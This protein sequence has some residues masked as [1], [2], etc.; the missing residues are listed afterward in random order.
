MNETHL[1]AAGRAEANIGT[2]RLEIVE[3]ATRRD[4]TIRVLS[5]Q[6]YLQVVAF[7]CSKT[8]IASGVYDNTIGKLEPFQNFFGIIGQR[9]EFG[10]RIFRARELD[11]L[12]FVELVLTE[13]TADVLAV[14]PCFTAETRSVGRE[15]DRQ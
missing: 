2:P 6:P 3:V 4:F 12:D 13:D 1:A 10:V 15:L 8:H 5:G 9:F 14:G 7:G 11:E